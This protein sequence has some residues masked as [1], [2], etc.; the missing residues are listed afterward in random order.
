V[1]IP[2]EECDRRG[3]G[4]FPCGRAAEFGRFRKPGAIAAQRCQT[5]PLGRRVLANSP[6]PASKCRTRAATVAAGRSP[7]QEPARGRPEFCRPQCEPRGWPTR[8]NSHD[9]SRLHRGARSRV[10]PLPALKQERPAKCSPRCRARVFGS[11]RWT[12]AL[13]SCQG[14]TRIPTGGQIIPRGRR[15]RGLGECSSAAPWT[16][17]CAASVSVGV[18]GGRLANLALLR[19]P[20]VA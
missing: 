3:A 6:P 16:R 13:P 17:C 8:R 19:D 15:W 20:I 5:A 4:V 9:Y 2:L 7:L 14:P 18:G 10:V 1:T 11:A 12:A